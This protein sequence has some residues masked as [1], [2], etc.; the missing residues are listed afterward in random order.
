MPSVIKDAVTSGKPVNS[1]VIYNTNT[2]RSNTSIPDLIQWGTM[3]IFD[4]LIEHYDRYFQI[5]TIMNNVLTIFS[6]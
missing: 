2:P 5:L 4:N 1:D 6:S 3:I